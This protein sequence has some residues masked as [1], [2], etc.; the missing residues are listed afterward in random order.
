[1]VYGVDVFGVKSGKW[2][3]IGEPPKRLYVSDILQQ[4]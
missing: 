1:M 2:N 3:D 4:S